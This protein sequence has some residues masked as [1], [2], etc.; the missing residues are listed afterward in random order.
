MK[1]VEQVKL[2]M[3]PDI[4]KVEKAFN[5][6]VIEQAK[7]RGSVAILSNHPLDIVE[8]QLSVRQYD[9]EETFCL[10]IFYKHAFL[11]PSEVGPDKAGGMAGGYSMVASQDRGRRR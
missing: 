3:A 1:I 4:K 6:W 9:G 8:R 7:E 2:F 11:E 10:A 5:A